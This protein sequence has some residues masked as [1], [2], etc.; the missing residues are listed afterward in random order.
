MFRVLSEQMVALQRCAIISVCIPKS[1]LTS[2]SYVRK[3]Y[4]RNPTP[5]T[6]S[7]DYFPPRPFGSSL[8]N[9]RFETE[10]LLTGQDNDQS[11]SSQSSPKTKQAVLTSKDVAELLHVDSKHLRAIIRANAD[12]ANNG[13]KYEFSQKD[14]PALQALV[15]EHTRKETEKKAAAKK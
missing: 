12:K 4:V 3:S 15:A 11:E 13:K 14:V 7:S 10:L 9:P 1:A 5:S 6:F 2:A 8:K